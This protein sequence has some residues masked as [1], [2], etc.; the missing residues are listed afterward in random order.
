MGG[1]GGGVVRQKLYGK[2][3]GGKR[4]G[5]GVSRFGN[6]GQGNSLT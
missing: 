2:L 6:C 1:G 4:K 5:G 3:Y